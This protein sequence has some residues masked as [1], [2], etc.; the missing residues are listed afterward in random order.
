MN[1]EVNY[2]RSY[3]PEYSVMELGAGFIPFY[4]IY[5]HKNRE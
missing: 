2:L 3:F 5:Y 1:A 4:Q